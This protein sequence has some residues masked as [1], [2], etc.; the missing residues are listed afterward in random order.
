MH[1]NRELEIL[2]GYVQARIAQLDK[3]L[4]SRLLFTL[5]DA[6]SEM[7]GQ[8]NCLMEFNTLDRSLMFNV[9]DRWTTSPSG[10][11]IRKI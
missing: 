1:E 9:E 8:I 11:L 5:S 3:D 10:K 7:L 2:K 4:D 6:Y